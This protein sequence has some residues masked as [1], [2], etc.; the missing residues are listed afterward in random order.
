MS[1]M[2]QHDGANLIKH[3]KNLPP[4]FDLL[5][6]TMISIKAES[7]TEKPHYRMLVSCPRSGSTLLMRILAEAPDCVVASR[8]MDLSDESSNTN[9]FVIHVDT[10][11]NWTSLIGYT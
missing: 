5:N 1:L 8:L 9:R 2:S 11:L 7:D 6:V 10:A 4:S 3:L